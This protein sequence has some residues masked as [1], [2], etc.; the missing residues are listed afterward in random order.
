VSRCATG[1]PW[2]TPTADAPKEPEVSQDRTV[3]AIIHG[4]VQGVGY[5]VWTK[6]EAERLGLSGH[7]RNRPDGT[8]AATFS[9]ETEAVATMLAACRKGPP[10]AGVTEVVEHDGTTPAAGFQI[11][12][13]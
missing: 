5:R 8:V 13:D 10:G 2:K 3:A 6:A 4:R 9:G 12:R 11:L 1:I 7:V